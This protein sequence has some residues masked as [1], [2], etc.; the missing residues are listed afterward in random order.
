MSVL[1]IYSYM[2]NDELL[3]AGQDLWW[4][5]FM[6][7]DCVLWLDLLMM[8]SYTVLSD[9]QKAAFK[10]VLKDITK[11]ESWTGPAKKVPV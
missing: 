10:F 1:Y 11:K 8:V 3:F 6:A 5:P 4:M 7:K 9:R 2:P